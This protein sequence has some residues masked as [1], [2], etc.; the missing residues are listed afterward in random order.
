MGR[1]ALTTN[2]FDF[3][4]EIKKGSSVRVTSGMTELFKYKH[5]GEPATLRIRLD[6]EQAIKNV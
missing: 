6:L 1:D 2:L 5:E 4:L 3:N